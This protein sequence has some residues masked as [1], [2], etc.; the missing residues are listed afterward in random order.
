MVDVVSQWKIEKMPCIPIPHDLCLPKVFAASEA[1]SLLGKKRS[2]G[3]ILKMVS[4]AGEHPLNLLQAIGK[5]EWGLERELLLEPLK[6]I[7]S[8]MSETECLGLHSVLSTM[9]SLCQSLVPVTVR[10][11]GGSPSWGKIK[12]YRS[13]LHSMG[14][15][16]HGRLPWS[17]SHI[18]DIS[19]AQVATRYLVFA[20][21]AALYRTFLSLLKVPRDDTTPKEWTSCIAMTWSLSSPLLFPHLRFEGWNMKN[22]VMIMKLI[23]NIYPCSVPGGVLSI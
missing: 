16:R 23:V 9:T 4:K 20:V 18:V 5:T 17:W 22:N 3:H 21:L 7:S 12:F 8:T 1:C 13:M 2:L 10:R 15:T 11:R 6:L 19:S 14:A